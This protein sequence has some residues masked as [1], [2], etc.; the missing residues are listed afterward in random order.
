MAKDRSKPAP[1]ETDDSE[2]KDDN[3]DAEGQRPD[4]GKQEQPTRRKGDTGPKA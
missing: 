4:G 3:L 2:Q 1:L